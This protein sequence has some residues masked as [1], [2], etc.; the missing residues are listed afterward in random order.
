MY[1]CA[2]LHRA[3]FFLSETAVCFH[4][5]VNNSD[6]LLLHRGKKITQNC[7]HKCASGGEAGSSGWFSIVLFTESSRLPQTVGILPSSGVW[8]STSHPKQF[9]L[10]V[11]FVWFIV[12]STCCSESLNGEQHGASVNCV[13]T[14]WWRWARQQS[15]SLTGRDRWHR[16]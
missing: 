15:N 5:L 14:R 7:N 2:G 12:F 3:S 9:K 11:A 6:K 10:R 13:L 4:L 16:G 8:S 1:R